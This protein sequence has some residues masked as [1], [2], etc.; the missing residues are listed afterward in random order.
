MFS[1][2]IVCLRFL[3]GGKFD[4]PKNTGKPYGAFWFQSMRVFAT[5]PAAFV[6]VLTIPRVGAK[7]LG[8]ME[9][10]FDRRDSAV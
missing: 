6:F 1:L 7:T 2:C 4:L 5:M 9:T 10:K 8:E 3:P